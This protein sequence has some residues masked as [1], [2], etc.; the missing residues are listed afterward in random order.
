MSIQS[1]TTLLANA[2]TGNGNSAEFPGGRCALILMGTLGTTN[3]LQAL[4]QDG[5]TWIDVASL[6]AAGVTNYDLPRGQYRFSVS[7]GT[8]AGIYADLVTVPY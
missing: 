5:N 2:G 1:K 6:S 4:G 3:K 7:G 8:P